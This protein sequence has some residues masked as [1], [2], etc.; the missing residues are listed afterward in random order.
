MPEHISISGENNPNYKWTDSELTQIALKYDYISDFKNKNG[1]AYQAAYGRNMLDQICIHMK[2]SKTC[3]SSSIA[4]LFL[5][6]E[7]KA[8]IPTAKKLRKEK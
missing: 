4:E 2:V 3:A 7:I 6:N 5:F 8:I 1:A